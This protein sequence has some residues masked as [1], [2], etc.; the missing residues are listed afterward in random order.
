M[1]KTLL[2]HNEEVYV[3][4]RNQVIEEIKKDKID[5]EKI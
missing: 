1:P 5:K 4:I 2:S 3:Q